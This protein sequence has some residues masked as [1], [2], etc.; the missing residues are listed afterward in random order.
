MNNVEIYTKSYCPF[1]KR[2]K[3]LLDAKGVSYQ[4]YEV[5]TDKKLQRE[6]L[7]RSGRLTVPQVFINNRHIG[8]SDDLAEAEESGLLDELLELKASLTA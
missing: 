1:C 7:V 2:A 6:M 8:G 4:D 3:A 5:S